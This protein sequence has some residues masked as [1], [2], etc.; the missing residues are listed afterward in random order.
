MWLPWLLERGEDELPAA[1]H[2]RKTDQRFENS[3]HNGVPR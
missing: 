3:T 2:R 1:S